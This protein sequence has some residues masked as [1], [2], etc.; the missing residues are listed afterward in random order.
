MDLLNTRMAYLGQIAQMDQAYYSEMAEVAKL[1][2]DAD[3]QRTFESQASEASD[4][5]GQIKR[6]W[7]TLVGIL[8]QG[9]IEASNK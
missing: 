9:M 8:S 6:A 3:S 2:G 5:E 1:N 4:R 7:Q